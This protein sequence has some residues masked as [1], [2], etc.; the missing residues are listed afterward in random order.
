[1]KGAAPWEGGQEVIILLQ[2]VLVLQA[3]GQVELSCESFC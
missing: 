1:M 2:V 3:W